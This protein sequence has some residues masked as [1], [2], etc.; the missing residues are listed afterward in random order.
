MLQ[1]YTS[2]LTE[3]RVLASGPFGTG[4]MTAADVSG[5]LTSHFSAKANNSQDALTFAS[6]S[7]TELLRL[8]LEQGVDTDAELQTLLVLEQAYAANAKVIE[9]VDLMFDALMRI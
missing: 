1:A 4:G 6:A 7:L 3:P 2:A 8:E 5:G 9:T